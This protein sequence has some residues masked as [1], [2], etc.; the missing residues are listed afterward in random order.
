MRGRG[1]LDLPD[2][3]PGD[4]RVYGTPASGEPA[5][6]REFAQ[7]LVG[8][9]GSMDGAQRITVPQPKPSDGER[10][11]VEPT[12]TGNPSTARGTLDGAVWISI[13]PSTSRATVGDGTAGGSRSA[14]PVKPEVPEPEH[15][16]DN[17][18]QSGDAEAA[19]R[20]APHADT[21]SA[22]GLPD[23]SGHE[24]APSI[25]DG[26][27]HEPSTASDGSA[28]DPSAT[29]GV[30]VEPAPFRV[31][32]RWSCSSCGGTLKCQRCHSIGKSAADEAT[33][34]I[35]KMRGVVIDLSDQVERTGL[36]RREAEARQ[37][38]AEAARREIE[39]WAA[40]LEKRAIVTEELL[41]KSEAEVERLQ[42]ELSRRPKGAVRQVPVVI[43]K[44]D[45]GRFNREPPEEPREAPRPPP[46]DDVLREIRKA[47][48]R[49]SPL[50]KFIR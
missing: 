14:A 27:R 25:S 21:R 23:G 41:Q 33:E 10:L 20:A 38:E 3:K 31:L 28:G 34:V 43:E 48:A 13:P 49:P 15:T 5:T 32:A 22:P 42:L 29:E 24:G 44:T 40:R 45:D 46:D 9:R 37:R 1:A 17:P 30:T 26:S 47:H 50:T 12:P 4:D 35:Q 7:P 39:R 2:G 6:Q 36:A 19:L 18:G 11:G 8:P 16:R